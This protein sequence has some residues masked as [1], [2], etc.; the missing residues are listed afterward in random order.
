MVATEDRISR[1]ENKIDDM[2][3]RLGRV[4]GVQ[5]E[6]NNRMEDVHRRVDDVHTR[7]GDVHMR[8]G[9]VHKRMEDVHKRLTDMN[10]RLNVLTGIIVTQTIAIVGLI[11]T[12][13]LGG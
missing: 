8:L 13:L 11:A 7:L 3:A 2:S 6:M 1:V 4:E 10:S 12:A 9:D 5:A